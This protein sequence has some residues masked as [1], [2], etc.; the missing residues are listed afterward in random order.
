M[1]VEHSIH[2]DMSEQYAGTIEL[3]SEHCSSWLT[4]AEI[5]L[6]LGGTAETLFF[7]PERET[8]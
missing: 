8:R 5:D 7:P 1:V 4:Q 6:I 2:Y 3:L